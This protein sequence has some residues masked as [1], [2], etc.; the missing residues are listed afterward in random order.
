M[1]G[2]H[3]ACRRC[4]LDTP[5]MNGGEAHSP[6]EGRRPLQIVSGDES[7]AVGAAGEAHEMVARNKRAG[8]RSKCGEDG[9]WLK[10]S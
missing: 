8:P 4:W 9:R 5:D 7:G 1:G 2:N 6:E 10:A 3:A